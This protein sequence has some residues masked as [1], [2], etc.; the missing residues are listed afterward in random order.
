[1]CDADD[2]KYFKLLPEMANIRATS[3]NLIISLKL[4]ILIKLCVSWF[5]LISITDTET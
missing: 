4:T 2:W 5:Q 1:M 3:F